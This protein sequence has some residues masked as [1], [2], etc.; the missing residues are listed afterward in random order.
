MKRVVG[1]GLLGLF[2]VASLIIAGCGNGEERGEPVVAGAPR[3]AQQGELR[4]SVKGPKVQGRNVSMTV[5]A[6]RV[7]TTAR[8]QKLTV[9]WGD[10]EH[11]VNQGRSGR[12]QH[13]YGQA[14]TYVIKITVNMTDG[15]TGHHSLNVTVN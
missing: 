13:T 2:V 3:S 14:G 1:W 12:V 8:Q 4:I 11:T 6:R 15:T 5:N 7:G 10:G 9:Q